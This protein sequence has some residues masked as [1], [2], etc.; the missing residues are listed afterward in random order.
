MHRVSGPVQGGVIAKRWDDGS[1]VGPHFSSGEH[2]VAL[3]DG[4]VIRARAVHPRTDTVKVTREAFNLIQNGPWDSSEVSAQDSGHKLAPSKEV[5]QHSPK[6]EPVPR[7]FRINQ[8]KL[9]KFGLTKG[10]PKCEALRRG[11]KHDTVHHS[12]E[13]RKRLEIEMGRD[14]SMPKKLSE[15]EETNMDISPG[16]LKRPTE[17]ES[18]PSLDQ[19]VNPRVPV[20]R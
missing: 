2:L 6:A 15:I 10:C 12:G 13:C 1:W 16:G 4:S 7:S 17:E 20:T 19:P 11:D 18:T 14:D 8:E 5:T 9:A 3:N